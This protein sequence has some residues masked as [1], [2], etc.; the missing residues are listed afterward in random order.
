MAT[1]ALLVLLQGDECFGVVTGDYAV[2]GLPPVAT[3]AVDISGDR[4]RLTFD[5]KSLRLFD[6]AGE[7]IVQNFDPALVY[8]SAFDNA[9]DHFVRGIG[10]G[11]PFET[12][13][14]DNLRTFTL[15]EDAYLAA[16]Q[17]C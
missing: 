2:P 13:L 7:V 5:G 6:L 17:A 15:V 14:E 3:D 11:A 4:G 10:A 12:S 1:T 9:I 8:Q 16:E